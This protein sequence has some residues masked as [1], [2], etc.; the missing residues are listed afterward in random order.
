M[1]SH[2]N[3]A[4][5][6]CFFFLKYRPRTER[7]IY[8]YLLKNT[9]KYKLKKENIFEIINHLKELGYVDDFK[10]IEWFVTKRAGGKPKAIFIIKS[11]LR[12]FGI[13]DDLI[14][15]YFEE[16]I[17]D[18]YELALRSLNL[19]KRK[20]FNLEPAER[21]SK[22]VTLLMRKGFRYGIAKKAVEEFNKKD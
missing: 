9:K 18:E 16:N 14:K 12:T 10:F 19:S 8:K 21:F 13:A 15:K 7:E 6:R 3:K 5:Q 11:E 2:L 22:T 20:I 17:I 4:L 1:Q